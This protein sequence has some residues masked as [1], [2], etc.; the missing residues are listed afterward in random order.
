MINIS[1]STRKSCSVLNEMF[2]QHQDNPTERTQKRKTTPGHE[3]LILL[4]PTPP[5][6]RHFSTINLIPYPENISITAYCPN[7]RTLREKKYLGQKRFI[8]AIKELKNLPI[9]KHKQRTINKTKFSM[10]SIIAGCECKT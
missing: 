1:N 9:C 2:R 7:K 5:K 8:G 3:N 10:H 4:P 6:H